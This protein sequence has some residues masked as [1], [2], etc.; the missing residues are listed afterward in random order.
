MKSAF[1]GIGRQR[2]TVDLDCENAGRR[3]CVVGQNLADVTDMVE[4]VLVESRRRG[5]RGKEGSATTSKPNRPDRL[6][7]L[8]KSRQG[9]DP[10]KKRR[11]KE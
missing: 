9:E 5:T 3:Q 10:R 6:K 11:Q 4:R 8:P 1:A 2:L 7:P